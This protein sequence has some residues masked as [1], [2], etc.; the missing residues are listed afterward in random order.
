MA[1]RVPCP[2]RVSMDRRPR[3]LDVDSF[4][5]SMPTP[6]PESSEACS[7]VEKPG[8]KTNSSAPCS[9]KLAACSGEMIPFSTAFLVTAR[10]SIPLPSSDTSIRTLSPR[11]TAAIRRSA[12]A[13]LL[14]AKRNSGSSI[15]WS[16]LFRTRWIMGPDNASTTVLSISTS[17][18]SISR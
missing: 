7:L 11:C 17:S 8:R 13:G 5:T 12:L 16:R 6:R 2:R 14:A 9:D 1:T 18:P 3:S 10:R 15:P 4:T